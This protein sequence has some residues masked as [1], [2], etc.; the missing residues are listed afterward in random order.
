MSSLQLAAKQIHRQATLQPRLCLPAG[1][2]VSLEEGRKLAKLVQ[3]EE[4][5]F[6]SGATQLLDDN[7][8]SPVQLEETVSKKIILMRQRQNKEANVRAAVAHAKKQQQ[9]NRISP[10]D[11]EKVKGI[12]NSLLKNSDKGNSQHLKGRHERAA[13]HKSRIKKKRH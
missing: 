9:R 7:A 8:S 12:A 1:R 4:E 3:D 13:S 6:T 5:R 10:D 2:T 11:A